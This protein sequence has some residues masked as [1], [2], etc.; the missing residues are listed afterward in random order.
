MAPTT[1][2]PLTV[3]IRPARP[4]A[5]NALLIEVQDL[6]LHPVPF[7]LR[8]A[9]ETDAAELTAV[10]EVTGTL[11]F[12]GQATLA[13]EGLQLRGHLQGEIAPACS[14]CLEPIAMTVERDLDLLYQPESVLGESA[15]V[16]I[17]ARDADVGFFSGPGVD[18]AE[19]ARE[20]ILLALPMQPLCR[21]DCRGLCAR[22]GAN[23][24]KGA[25]SC[26]PQADERW[27]ALKSLRKPAR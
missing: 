22:C 13:G 27:N 23:L 11:H 20:Q 15:E 17:H 14:R 18:V 1:A 9:P 2:G 25:C 7:D 4:C 24:N 6:R 12:H 16:E 19:V 21:P 5:D 8:L 26:A 3:S 10:P